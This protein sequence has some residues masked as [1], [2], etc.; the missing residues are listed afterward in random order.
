[1]ADEFV[2]P[3]S[4]LS[5]PALHEAKRVLRM[6]MIAAREALDADVRAAASIRIAQ[7]VG[8]LASFRAARCVLLTLPYRSEWDTRLLLDAALAAGKDVALPRVN[9]ATRMLEMHLVSDVARDT[10]SGYRGIPEP[11]ANLPLVP[12]DAIDWVLVPG[13]AFDLVGRRLG[14]GGGFYDRLLLLLPPATPRVAGA[15]VMQVVARVPAAPHDLAV[16]QIVTEQRIL[17]SP[18]AA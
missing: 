13:V 14:Y 2:Q 8:A 3:S 7:S 11:L 5:G 16:Q 10:A 6:Q 9:D 1:M 12:R 18:P 17:P 15:F 4:V